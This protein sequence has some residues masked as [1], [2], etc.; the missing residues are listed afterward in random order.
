MFTKEQIVKGLEL[1]KQWYEGW[2]LEDL[3]SDQL[4]EAIEKAE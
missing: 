2:K 1:A 3:E 4:I